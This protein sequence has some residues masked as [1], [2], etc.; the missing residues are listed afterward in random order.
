[1]VTMTALHTDIVRILEVECEN[2]DHWMLHGIA[3]T[4]DE[5]AEKFEMVEGEEPEEATLKTMLVELEEAGA[6]I[7]CGD[8]KFTVPHWQRLV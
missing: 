4:A 1:M 2:E 3:R 5:I 8:D 7:R 6:I